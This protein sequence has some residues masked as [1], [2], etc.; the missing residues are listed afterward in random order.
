[1]NK[2]EANKLI[3][4][5]LVVADGKC[6]P[7]CAITSRKIG[8]AKG[9]CGKRDFY[10]FDQVSGIPL[11]CEILDGLFAVR[12]FPHKTAYVLGVAAA[13]LMPEQDGWFG[14]YWQVVGKL[15]L[16]TR[17]K[18]VHELQIF[19]KGVGLEYDAYNLEER[20]KLSQSDL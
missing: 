6:E 18:Y 12:A 16:I 2:Q 9:S 10:R 1:M 13:Y 20:L 14:V 15:K 5:S 8:V 3:I 7:I 11:R 17:I 4:G 19:L